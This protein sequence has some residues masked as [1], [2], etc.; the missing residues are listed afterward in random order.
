MSEHETRNRPED[1]EGDVREHAV[2]QLKKRRDLSAHVVT[3]L[4]VVG[5]G[6]R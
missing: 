6:G 2:Q 1:R 3:N 4:I 5:A